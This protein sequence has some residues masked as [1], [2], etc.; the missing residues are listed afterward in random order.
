MDLDQMEEL[1]KSQNEQLNNQKRLNKKLIMDITQQRLKAKWD[2]VLQYET[3]GAVVCISLGLVLLF[4]LGYF[5]PWYIFL[6]GLLT[7]MYMLLFPIFTLRSIFRL[8]NMTVENALFTDVMK[9]YTVRKREFV[10]IQKIGLFFNSILFVI[11][12]PALNML[13]NGKDIFVAQ[14]PLVY[15][16]LGILCVF[17][18]LASVWAYK[19]YMRVLVRTEELL[20]DMDNELAQQ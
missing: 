6:S 20:K 5:A 15:V 7:C 8:K 14:P 10:T 9:S 18:I 13:I 1:W 19:K 11:S 16:G 2:T 17:T 3:L 12:L 4:K